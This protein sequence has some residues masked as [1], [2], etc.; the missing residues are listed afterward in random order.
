MTRKKA[1]NKFKRLQPKISHELR[2]QRIWGHDQAVL[3]TES[4]H[5]SKFIEQ[6]AQKKS[7]VLYVNLKIK[8][9]VLSFFRA[10]P[11][12]YGGSQASGPIRAVA[13]H[14]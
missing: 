2:H 9:I 4:I 5:M 13:A 11:A 6:Y 14:L 12:A 3:Y 8:R 10:T 7:I 1:K